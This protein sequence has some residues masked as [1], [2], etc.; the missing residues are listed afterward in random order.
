MIIKVKKKVLREAL[1]LLYSGLLIGALVVGVSMTTSGVAGV[2]VTNATVLAKVNVTNTEPFLNKVKIDAPLDFNGNINLDAG[3]AVTVICNGSFQDI[4]GYDDIASVN[5]TFYDT[6]VASDAPDDNNTHYTN[7]S[8]GTCTLVEGTNN[9]NGTCICQFAVQYYANP[10]TWQCNMTIAD[11][12]GLAS[13]QNSSFVRINEVLGL[14]VENSTLDYGDLSVTEISPYIRENVTNIGNIPINITVRGYGGTNESIGQN[15]TMIC[16]DN[17]A[18]NITFDYQRFALEDTVSF[19]D[20][21]NLTNQTALIQNLTI[22]KRT[23]N[24]GYGNS[25]NSTFWRLQI[26]IGAAGV[27]NGTLIFGAVDAS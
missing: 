10:T 11:S 4:N 24:V 9:Q 23:T 21:T 12:S 1:F 18:A 20:M 22:P 17:S 26:P 3:D 15:V 14:A 27:C 16:G 6:S 13:T 5:A 19:D 8:C 2:N 25:T 7:S